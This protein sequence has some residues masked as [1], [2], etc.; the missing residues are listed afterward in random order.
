MSRSA[1]GPEGRA[2][3]V[4]AGRHVA[5]GELL[6]GAVVHRLPVLLGLHQLVADLP[7]DLHVAGARLAAHVADGQMHDVGHFGYD[8]DLALEL[9]G[10]VHEDGRGIGIA[11]IDGGVDRNAGGAPLP[12]HRVVAARI[13]GHVDP[14]V[15][16]VLEVLHLVGTGSSSRPSSIQTG[17]TWPDGTT[18]SKPWPPAR[19]LASAV[20]LESKSVT[21]TLTSNSFSNFSISSGLV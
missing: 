2:V 12:R 3:P 4:D 19:T 14:A 20:S 18:M 1:A 15:G 10:R 13:E 16:H 8:V 11:V 7:Q 5:G 9:V 17:T 21:V 6:G